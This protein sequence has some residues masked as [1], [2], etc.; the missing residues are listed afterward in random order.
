MFR[1]ERDGDIGWPAEVFLLDE[2]KRR[3]DNKI[4]LAEVTSARAMVVRLKVLR[5]FLCVS[6]YFC[7]FNSM[8]SV[9]SRVTPSSPTACVEGASPFGETSISFSAGSAG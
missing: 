9:S 2:R 5:E 4:A 7:G 3:A 6:F 1:L 8:E